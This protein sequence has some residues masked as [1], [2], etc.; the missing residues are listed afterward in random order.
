MRG[1]PNQT[2]AR[3]TMRS[4]SE[5]PPRVRLA[6]AV[7]GLALLGFAVWVTIELLSGHSVAV[8]ILLIALSYL[9]VIVI[10]S[11]VVTLTRMAFSLHLVPYLIGRGLRRLLG[12]H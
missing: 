6:L 7:A 5:L 4:V 9:G 11:A 8:S 3:P 1:R 10:G 2:T 12:L